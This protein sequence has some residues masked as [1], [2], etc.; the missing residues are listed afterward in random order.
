MLHLDANLVVLSACD[1]AVGPMQ[2]EEGISTLSN[3]FLLAGA[4]AVVSTLWFADDSSSLFLMQ[5]FYSRLAK[6]AYPAPALAE[7]KREMLTKFG[8]SGALP[9][10]WAGFKFEG[11]SQPKPLR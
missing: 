7:A 8:G 6:G 4:K 9:Y 11:V 3:S 2:G 1:T 10:Y 5:T